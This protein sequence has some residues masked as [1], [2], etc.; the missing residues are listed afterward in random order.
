M[1]SRRHPPL[2]PSEVVAI[3]KNLKFAFKRQEGD[4]AQWERPADEKRLRAVVTVN[5]GEKEFDDYIMQS[6]IRQSKH[7]REEFYG[8]TKRTA[9]KASVK[10]LKVAETDAD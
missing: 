7:S 8:A 9:R 1:G 10:F 6:M 2:T 4:H 5:M 3:L